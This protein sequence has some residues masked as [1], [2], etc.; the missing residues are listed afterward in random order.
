[1]NLSQSSHRQTFIDL[2]AEDIRK[3]AANESY[4]FPAA[5]ARVLLKWLGYEND[6][7]FIDTKDR[8][9]DAWSATNDGF[10]LFQVKTHEQDSDGL[11]DLSAFDGSG[12]RD[13]E[14]AKNF[15]VTERFDKVPQKDLRLLVSRRDSALRSH[16]LE[17]TAT[18]IPVTFHLV[19]LGNVLTPQAAAEFQAFQR[20]NAEPI[21][22]DE[23]PIQIYAVLHTIDD[24]I[25]GK[26][27]E[28]N[29]DWMD[30]KGRKQDRINL[31]TSNEGAIND[32][33]NAIFYCKASDLVD[34]YNALGYQIFEPNVRANIS[35]SRV[36]QA[37][38]DSVLHQ[39]SRRE[40]RFLNNGVTI[41]C[42]SF[43]KPNNQRKHF[44]VIH[45]GIVNGLQTVVA[46]H[47]AFQQLN[48]RDKEDFEQNCSVMVRLLLNT[49]VDDITKV[50]KATNNQNPMKPRNLV[51]NNFE[52]LLYARIFAED[53]SWFYES[54]EGAWEAFDQDPKR[55]RP[56]LSKHPR[57][58]KTDRRKT[59]R[60]DNAD[61]AQTWLAFIGFASEA[62]NEK[63]TLFE[64]RFYALIFKQQPR[65]HGF[66]YDFAL[67]RAR[68]DSID[69]SP[70][71][72]LMLVSYLS[73]YFVDAVV[74]TASQNRQAACTRL[75]ID[76]SRLTKSDLDAR[77]SGD[78][79]FI[80]NQILAGMS[81]LFTEFVGFV[82]YRTFGEN[83][84]HLGKRILDNHSFSMMAK[85]LAPEVIKDHIDSNT[86]N[87]KDLL[88]V[89]WLLFVETIENMVAS[90]WEENYRAAPIKVRFIFSRETRERLYREIQK[91]NEFMKKR[92]VR[93]PWAIG[94]KEGQ[95]LFDFIRSCIME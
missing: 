48:Q 7:T 46:L 34:A 15:W 85:S 22:L 38:R 41:T 30:A 54:K 61:L 19:I 88:C 6:M 27:R 36:N 73:W 63:K 53:L 32:N 35:N 33:H 62:V 55:W 49:A 28:R 50:V 23:I 47:T 68:E 94:V 80:L 24:V 67:A 90:G 52:Q 87:E 59:R 2:L 78:N 37:I 25:D 58:F 57:E 74:P 56:A 81:L 11:L 72:S 17:A 93:D 75:G 21:L 8:G 16:R 86:F 26:W 51:S 42:D 71:A 60:L 31:R 1:M 10:D 79:Q 84:H 20:A 65:K 82:L 69:L 45:P 18:A 83:I 14:R 77:L 13:L 91:T 39:R 4:T 92:S 70:S 3:T 44:T 95:G 76:P 12:I 66:D 5:A 40:F 29:R 43:I 9:I 64:D 89:L